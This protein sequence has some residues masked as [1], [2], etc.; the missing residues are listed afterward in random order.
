M[1]EERKLTPAAVEEA[2]KTS[3]CLGRL[4]ETQ[5]GTGSCSL[6]VHC[7]VL[8]FLDDYARWLAE[9]YGDS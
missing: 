7:D 5:P 6:G 9:D 2:S 8:S 4:L 3:A 1:L